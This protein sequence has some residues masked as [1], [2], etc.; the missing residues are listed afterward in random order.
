MSDKI[1]P[2]QAAALMSVMAYPGQCAEVSTMIQVIHKQLL[3]EIASGKVSESFSTTIKMDH[4]QATILV[5]MFSYGADTILR[6]IE[7]MKGKP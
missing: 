4:I 7:S 2:S 3:D 6:H 5:A 1:D